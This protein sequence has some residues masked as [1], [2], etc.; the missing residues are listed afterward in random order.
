MRLLERTLLVV[1]PLLVMALAVIFLFMA[2]G[3]RI[4]LD[5]LVTSLDNSS[6]RW[7]LGIGSVI[8]LILCGRLFLEN[9]RQP[10]ITQAVVREGSFGVV[11]I[12][13]H[14]LENL[15]VRVALQAKGMK[16]VRP[17]VKCVSN[18]VVVFLKVVV[19]TDTKIPEV[20][21][22][23]QR[24]IKQAV[25]ECAGIE[26]LETQVLVENIGQDQRRRVE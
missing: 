14:A 23:L 18:G 24:S 21:E 15:V 12:T 26:V 5:A 4:P 13:L 20:T 16:D 2:L 19:E 8:L 22:T 17:R 6:F 7:S 10:A 3:W 11:R 1:Y 25:E 9:F